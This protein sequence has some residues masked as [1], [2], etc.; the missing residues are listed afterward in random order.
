MPHP[1]T[2][3]V[4]LGI[5]ATGGC[6]TPD[7]Q[8]TE[9]ALA[10]PTAVED[11]GDPTAIRP[12]EITVPDEVLEDLDRRL[13]QTRFPDQIG[14]SWVYGTDVTYLQ[15]LIA[16]WRDEYDWREQETQLNA[17]DH[18]KTEI[19]DLDIHFIHQRSPE[20][21]ALP[22]VITHG[23]PGSIVEFLKVIGPL[24][25]PVAHGG[26]AEDAFHVI[27]PSMPG[28]GFSDKPREPG[29]GP[30]QIADINAQL[31]A[32][33]GYEHYGAQGGDWGAGV[34]RWIAY[35]YAPHVVGLHLN[36]VL[37]GPPPDS[38]DPT[39]GATPE[40]LQRMQAR[41][42]TLGEGFAYTQIQGTKP[43][44]LGYGLN[45][46]PAGLA[47]WIIEKFQSWCDCNGDPESIF[48]KDELL[49]NIMVYWVTETAT[50]AARLYYES[51]H[52]STGGLITEPPGRIDVPT[53]AA[54]FPQELVLTP[55]RW[56][57]AHYNITHW[58]EMPRGGHFAAFEQPEL[59][60]EDVR[61]FYRDLR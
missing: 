29:M 21:D 22:V 61:T 6:G 4:L 12:F 30:E 5:V 24:T 13:G 41:R 54:I 38:D 8:P 18:Y 40:E 17:F 47:G 27:A 9:P 46:S 37:S 23:W 53:G 44:S 51:S 20:P 57:E 39:G 55:R 14:D 43:Q 52:Q 26:N 48:T 50:S 35:K 1:F 7:N 59:F 58:T 56:A 16:Y 45:D 33:L 31:M 3:F 19:D 49:T 36:M 10:E 11:R 42:A 32:R 60:V 34:S 25:D 28:Y 15:E 2:G